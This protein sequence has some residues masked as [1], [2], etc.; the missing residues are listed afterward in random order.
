MPVKTRLRLSGGRGLALRRTR[1]RLS[2]V[3]VLLR[4]SDTV[5]PDRDTVHDDAVFDCLFGGLGGAQ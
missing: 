3:H 2:G 5:G 4:A 1:L